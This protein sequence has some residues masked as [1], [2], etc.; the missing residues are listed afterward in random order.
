[1]SPPGTAPQWSESVISRWPTRGLVLAGLAVIA[2]LV[3]AVIDHQLTVDRLPEVGPFTVDKPAND[4]PRVAERI[5]LRDGFLTRAWL[6]CLGVIATVAA[7]VV[8]GLRS[9]PRVRWHELFADL[10]VAAVC[11]LG[12]ASAIS[13]SGPVMLNEAR[14]ALVW[15]PP[16]VMI[17]VAGTGSLLTCRKDGT[18]AISTGPGGRASGPAQCDLREESLASLPWIGRIAFGFSVLTVALLVVLSAGVAD[19]EC[20]A[21]AGGWVALVVLGALGSGVAVGGCGVAAL[22]VRRWALSLLS[23][24]FAAL[25]LFLAVVIF[26]GACYS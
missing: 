16:V 13:I 19:A 7:V 17:L 10:G 1:M 12:L 23:I 25:A 18:L 2:I 20:G 5:R 6:Y 22:V 21:K 26:V 3:T 9:A 15:L 4:N 8:A 24:A 11:A 14:K